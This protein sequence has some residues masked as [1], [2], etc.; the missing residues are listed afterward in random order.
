MNV[1]STSTGTGHGAPSGTA[2]PLGE[3]GLDLRQAPEEDVAQP[4]DQRP[5]KAA[6]GR[7]AGG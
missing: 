2:P 7:G 6:G 5:P 3:P 1:F 4:L